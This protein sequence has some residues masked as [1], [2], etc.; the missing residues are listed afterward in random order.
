MA[1]VAQLSQ[2]DICL[3]LQQLQTNPEN[4]AR[5]NSLMRMSLLRRGLIDLSIYA[6][7]AVSR[8]VLQFLKKQPRAPAINFTCNA[9]SAQTQKENGGAKLVLRRE[10]RSDAQIKTH[11]AALIAIAQLCFRI[12]CVKRLSMPEYVQH[13]T[14]KCITQAG[15][16]ALNAHQATALANS[17]RGEND[18]L[19]I[20]LISKMVEKKLNGQI[21]AIKIDNFLRTEGNWL[22][23]I[24]SFGEEDRD[25][26]QNATQGTAQGRGKEKKARVYEIVNDDDKMDV[27]TDVIKLDVDDR[28]VFP[29]AQAQGSPNKR[30]K[31]NHAKVDET[32]ELMEGHERRVAL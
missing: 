10:K 11:E 13:I 24:Q 22:E 16:L 7:A 14:D 5:W 9:P 29:S 17:C 20:G 4:V 27:D 25:T 19:L 26:V 1:P 30:Q 15:K 2:A 32:L 6:L 8:K 12:I 18:E 21:A 3:F 28:Q 31:I 23:H